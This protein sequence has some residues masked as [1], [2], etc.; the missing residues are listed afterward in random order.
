MGVTTDEHRRR[1]GQQRV[2]ACR[3]RRQHGRVLVPIEVGPLQLAALE[4]LA[5]LGAG[6]RDKSAIARAVMRFL[7][8]ASHVSALGDALWP[9]DEE[10]SDEGLAA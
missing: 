6:E 5:L 2:E 1:L 9:V 10:P 7:D 8:A 4:R 3:D